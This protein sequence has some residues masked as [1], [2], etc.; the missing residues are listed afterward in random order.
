MEITTSLK[1]ADK[2]L[3]FLASV[4]KQLPYATAIALNNTAKAVEEA[5]KKEMPKAFDNPTPWTL[6]SLRVQRARKNELKAVVAVKDMAARGNPALFWMGPEV[7]GG[8]RGDK[9][10]EKA[11]KKAGLLPSSRHV[12]PGREAALNRFG[13]MTKSSIVKAVQGAQAAEQKQPQD[14]RTKYFVMRKGSQP[15]G[16]AARFNKQRMGM[17]LAF[18]RASR[19]QSRLDY[20]GIGQKTV[21]RVYKDELNKA[22]Q[23]AIETAK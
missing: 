16:I 8:G 6:N 7:H 19:Y 23:H 2:A 14:G 4:K 5:I 22:I 11:L 12:V 10:A 13:N 9:R 3:A 21:R 15:I 20:Y 18:V 1:D 17:V